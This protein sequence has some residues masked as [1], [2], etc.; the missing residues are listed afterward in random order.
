MIILTG[1][2]GR[3]MDLVILVDTSRNSSDDYNYIQN[4]LSDFVEYL[5]INSGAVRVAM[6]T[7][8]TGPIVEFKLN[9]HKSILDVQKGIR[10][11]YQYPGDR[12]TADAFDALR[13][14][15]FFEVYGDRP[16]VPDIILFLTTGH[17]NRNTHRTLQEADALHYFNVN[18][19]GVGLGEFD[20]TE[21]EGIV[22]NPAKKNL[23][24]VN[25]VQELPKFTNQI[26]EKMCRRESTYESFV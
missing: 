17:S 19:L 13:R 10:N 1:C 22:S 25:T 4:F 21:L 14:T 18:I 6:V 24:H 23:L 12:N 9:T 2:D 8:S 7:F 20:A 3:S 11:A 5:D 16:Q 15:V 26:L